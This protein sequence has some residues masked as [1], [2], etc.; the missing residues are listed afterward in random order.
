[1]SVSQ[2]V[3]CTLIGEDGPM[4][5]AGMVSMCLMPIHLRSSKGEKD[6]ECCFAVTETQRKHKE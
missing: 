4:V 1:M 2:E 6:A 5:M 3:G